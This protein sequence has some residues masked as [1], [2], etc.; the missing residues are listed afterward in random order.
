MGYARH[1][2]RVG[3]L[4]VTL[5]VGVAIA[6]APGTA[7]ADSSGTSPTGDS[8]S[9]NRFSHTDRSSSKNESWSRKSSA[10]KRAASSAGTDVDSSDKKSTS[11]SA[12][13]A[14]GNDGAG[15]TTAGDAGEAGVKEATS[16]EEA[17]PAS[18]D[19]DTLS[20]HALPGQEEAE[21]KDSVSGNSAD[22][23][24]SNRRSSAHTRLFADFSRAVDSAVT[25]ATQLNGKTSEKL[26]TFGRVETPTTYSFAPDPT[27]AVK[28]AATTFSEASA[29][30]ALAVPEPRSSVVTIVTDLLGS[31]LHPL[32]YP[33]TGSPP[34]EAPTLMAILAATR[35]EIER[36]LRPRSA[37]VAYPQTLGQPLDYPDPP[38]DPTKQHVLVVAIDGTNMSRVL[39]DD[40]NEN[41]F[42]LMDT[43]TNSAPSIVGHTTVSNPSWT[44]ILTGAWDNKTGVINNVYTPR[45]YDRWP[46]VFTQLE[47][48][49]PAIETK[50]I[51]DW[52]VIG[53]IAASG[54]VGADEVVYISQEP[55]D[56]N[57]SQTDAAVTAEAV[58]TINDTKEGPNFLVTYLV[59]VD[60][61]GHL[62]GADS[63]EY[64][65]AIQRTDDNLGA[66]LDA[67]AAREKET[68]KSASTCE[69]W[70]V[71]VVTDHGHQPQQGFGHGFQSPDETTTFVIADGPQ[72]GDGVFNPD[73]EIV[74]VTPTVLN[75]F[76]A[77]Q[78]NRLDGV[79]LTS[80]RG[81]D[82]DPLSQVQLHDTLKAQMAA[83]DYPNII[84]NVALSLRTIVAFVPNYLYGADLPAPL[85]DI[86][87]VAT[88]V[89]AQVVAFVTGVHGVRLF[90]LLPPPPPP[91]TLIPDEA[92]SIDA[93]FRVD[94]GDHSLAAAA[95]VAS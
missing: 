90:P 63:E 85:G 43:S 25:A 22:R 50:A 36:I 45:T 92:T 79:P 9:I 87:Y 5:G 86:L 32:L 80:L 27:D 54:S 30:A 91:T 20:R 95:C 71:I 3:A 24:A 33:G 84:V 44:A 40:T 34:L 57:W 67:V 60:E 42:E 58:K 65:Q 69:D 78:G 14:T 19:D 21:T 82:S 47:T 38:A 37:P 68:C 70:T 26:S 59:Q 89:P 18:S 51:A 77:P 74:D 29:P 41:F 1:I 8:P 53:A 61:N 23:K 81:S 93:A 4:A 7:Y 46:T 75:L 10:R 52:D 73:Y 6:T 64:K 83:N 56:T 72:F 66:I 17:P 2:G 31:V 11:R 62:Y 48:Y 55:N 15:N 35:D 12:A 13:G 94:C 76:G 88:N 39:A 49:N 28:T 16:G